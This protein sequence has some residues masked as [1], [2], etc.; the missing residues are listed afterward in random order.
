MG[1]VL[2]GESSGSPTLSELPRGA[3]G[4]AHR[5][6]DHPA[7]SGPPGS[8]QSR[9]FRRTPLGRTCAPARRSA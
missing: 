3:V 7:G 1:A 6:R 2:P 4:Q 8:A 9:T 5:R